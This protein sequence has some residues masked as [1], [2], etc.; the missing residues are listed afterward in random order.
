MTAHL[1]CPCITHHVLLSLDCPHDHREQHSFPTRRSSDLVVPTH[2][3]STGSSQKKLTLL[4]RL[5]CHNRAWCTREP[6]CTELAARN[7][8]KAVQDAGGIALE[9]NAKPARH[10]TPK[11]EQV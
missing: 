4:G 8:R 3:G 10:P 7:D 9:G 2:P 5:L 11:K 1:R 6:I